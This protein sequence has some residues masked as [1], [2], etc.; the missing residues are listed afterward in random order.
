M[1]RIGGYNLAP[2]IAYRWHSGM[3]V[4]VQ[5]RP[6]HV[7]VRLWAASRL[8][9]LYGAPKKSGVTGDPTQRRLVGQCRAGDAFFTPS[10]RERERVLTDRTTRHA[11]FTL[12]LRDLDPPMLEDEVCYLAA[13][14][15]LPDGRAVEAGP[16]GSTTPLLGFILIVPPDSVYGQDAPNINFQGVA[17]MATGAKLGVPFS[18]TTDFSQKNSPPPLLIALPHQCSGIVLRTDVDGLAYSFDWG[19]PVTAVTTGVP[20]E[21]SSS[22][23][24]VLLASLGAKN[25]PFSVDTISFLYNR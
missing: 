11:R 13:Q 20:V 6:D 5:N 3:D 21:I 7:A 16:T 2:E 8:E 17:P 15:V 14:Q 23:K 9:D 10:L 12:A 18:A 22:V 1:S 4:L 19:M 25:A 24:Y